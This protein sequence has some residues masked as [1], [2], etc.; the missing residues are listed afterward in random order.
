MKTKNKM[1]DFEAKSKEWWEVVKEYFTKEL[2]KSPAQHKVD[3]RILRYK[4][5]AYQKKILDFIC[6]N[7]TS[8]KVLSQAEETEAKLSGTIQ[9]EEV[10]IKKPQ[11]LKSGATQEAKIQI[12]KP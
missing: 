1:K 5:E 12:E 4:L 9:E 7:P 10:H 6:S 8:T 2:E 11:D 3:E